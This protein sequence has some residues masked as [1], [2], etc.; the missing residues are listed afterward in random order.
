MNK[1]IAIFIISNVPLCRLHMQA[2]KFINIAVRLNTSM[3]VASYRRLLH[4]FQDDKAT[5]S[6]L[7]EE[8]RFYLSG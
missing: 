1:V 5:K 7:M 4:L 6:E 3:N 8:K 2:E